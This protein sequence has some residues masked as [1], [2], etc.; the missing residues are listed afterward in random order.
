MTEDSQPQTE[1][2]EISDQNSTAFRF[3]GVVKRREKSLYK[4]F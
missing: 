2:S 4:I 3:E 1:S